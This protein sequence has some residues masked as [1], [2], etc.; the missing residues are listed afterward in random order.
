MKDVVE[1]VCRFISWCKIKL[2]ISLQVLHFVVS[3]VDVFVS[4]L[5]DRQPFQS[6][7][8]LKELCLVTGIVCNMALTE[9]AL[10]ADDDLGQEQIQLRGP[11]ARIERLMIGLLPRYCSSDSWEKVSNMREKKRERKMIS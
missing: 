11:L 6:S 4:I 9:D 5:Q 8:S 2:F 7:G 3:H 1:V 10:I